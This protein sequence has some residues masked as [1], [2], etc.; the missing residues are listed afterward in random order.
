MINENVV[1][2]AY[3]P[4]ELVDKPDKQFYY[5]TDIILVFDTETTTDKEQK[6]LFGTCK[7]F[8]SDKLLAVYL[9][10]ADDLKTDDVKTIEQYALENDLTLMN[11]SDF[12]DRIFLPYV[13]NAKALCVGFNLP[14]DISRLAIRY[15]EARKSLKRGFS[16]VLSKNPTMPR[17]DIKSLDSKRSFYSI[18]APRDKRDEEYEYYRGRFL[19][20]RTFAFALTSKSYSLE[21]VAE[22]FDCISRKT[23]PNE[24]GRITPDYIAY[25]INDVDVTYELYKKLMERYSTFMLDIPPEKL[26]S[27]AS[28]AKAY[29]KNYGIKPFMEQNKDFPKELLGYIMT[30]YYG[31]RTEVK[32]RKSPSKVTYLD[33]TSMYPSVYTLT[34]MDS[35]LKAEK[36]R[37]EDATAET[38][39]FLEMVK[40]EDFMDKGTWKRLS[41]ICEIVP[42]SDILPVRSNYDGGNAYTIGLNIVSSSDGTALW[43][44][45]AD[46]VADKFLSGRVPKIKTAIK[47]LRE[48]VQNSIREINIMDD[49]TISPEENIVRKLIDE[50][51]EIKR[52]AGISKDKNEIR[53]LTIKQKAI[54]TI[55]NAMSY[56]I[57]VELDIESLEKYKNV[58]VYGLKKF[59]CKVN[60]LEKPGSKFNP[61]I[62]TMLTSASRLVLG[63]AE[64]LLK[65]N[66]GYMVY[67]DTDSVM[68]SPQHKGLIQSFFKPLNPYKHETDM[69]KV[70]KDEDGR[71]LENV[72]FYGISAKR[73]ALFD[74]INGNPIIRTSSSHGLGNLEGIQNKE[75]W[76][77]ILK[78]ELN[79][80]GPNEIVRKYS[81][82]F[83][84]SELNVTKPSIIKRFSKLGIIR[85]FNFV[86]VGRSC[87]RDPETNEP[88]IPVHSFVNSSKESFNSLV[89]EPFIDYKS[90]KL[91]EQD[92]QLYWTPMEEVIWDYWKHPESKFK[93]DIGELSRKHVIFCPSDIKYIGKESN[94]L[95][96]SEVVGILDGNYTVYEDLAEKARGLTETDRIRLGISKRRY[97][98][99][100]KRQEP[101]RRRGKIIKRIQAYMD[102]NPKIRCQKSKVVYER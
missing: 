84:I 17:I 3:A 70:E 19:D 94:E 25:N 49:I 5:S 15:G 35:F 2:R 7:I 102:L 47:F 57:F 33:F 41:V 81:G 12:V 64:T 58:D 98:Q 43:Y 93:G 16:F 80:T 63:I 29:L 39:S 69:F 68:I 45:L 82:K 21:S 61:L 13:Y 48:G 34:D 22:D 99:I 1:L 75:I 66:G 42:D 46:L 86:L 88:I 90:G 54:K 26:L 37:Y 92:T 71:P 31:G 59:T 60:R 30:T 95:E 32:I 100:R 18:T 51:L 74:T 53:Q 11:R 23:H 50:R 10:Y 9:F 72:D 24:H 67:C 44:S 87:R 6:L 27:P 96:E 89:Y 91:Y 101:F 76:E 83:A 38:Q 85:P 36:I 52:K 8:I 14:F 20:L 77:D 28:L 73:Y 56:G 62:A 79:N 97:Y 55:V 40:I 4:I 65:R 78:I